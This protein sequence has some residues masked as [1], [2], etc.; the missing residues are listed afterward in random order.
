MMALV[1]ICGQ[2]WH[3]VERDLV[4]LNWL[5]SEDDSQFIHVMSG[6]SLK[7]WRLAPIIL[8]S[9]PG[10][11]VYHAETRGESALTPEAQLLA[12]LSEQY[13]G[14]LD[15]NARYQR[16][17]G[18]STPLKQPRFDSFA[19]LPDYGGIKLDVLPADELVAKREELAKAARE[20]GSKDRTIKDVYRPGQRPVMVG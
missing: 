17:G 5:W 2:H 12:N 7:F 16:P 6:V 11:A 1:R 8:A 10:S 3:A 20:G 19:A 14:V 18:N 15:L 13:A 9:P 4:A